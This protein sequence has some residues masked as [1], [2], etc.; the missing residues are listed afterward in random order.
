M[1][2]GVRRGGKRVSRRVSELMGKF[3]KVGG[4]LEEEE[5][6]ESDVCVKKRAEEFNLL[7]SGIK[8]L[9]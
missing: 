4:P 1:V 3:E 5:T 2:G 6:V 9:K 8:F 7:G